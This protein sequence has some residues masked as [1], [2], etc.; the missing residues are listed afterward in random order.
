MR[1]S[2]A[3]YRWFV[4]IIIAVIFGSGCTRKFYRKRADDDVVGVMTEKNKSPLWAIENWHIYPDPRARFADPDNPDRPLK[5]PDDPAAAA[6]SPDPQPRSAKKTGIFEG[7]VYLSYLQAWDADNREKKARR[8][9]VARGQTPYGDKDTGLSASFEKTLK[10]DEQGFLI[11][12]EQACELSLFNSREYQDRREDLYASALPVTLERFSYVAQFSATENAIRA[13]TGRKTVDGSGDRW[14]L[15]SE[16]G[17]SKLFPSG[18]AL[19]VKLANR[20]VIELGNG[21]PRISFSTLAAEL[22]QPLLAGGGFAVTM[23]SLTQA[24]RNLLYAVRSYARFRKIYYTYLAGGNDNLFNS[25]Y[26]LVGLQLRG[27]G[28]TLTASGQGFYPTLLLTALERNEVE[29]IA[30][31]ERFWR[32]YQAFEEGGDVSRLQVDQVE[33]QLLRGRSQLLQRR[34][35]LQTGLDTF[36]IQL[37][38]PTRL[39]LEL[40]DSPLSPIFGHLDRFTQAR[41][42]FDAIRK[43]AGEYNEA[44]RRPMLALG[45]GLLSTLPIDI[46]LRPRMRTL[47]TDAPAVRGTRF[48]E[49]ILKRWTIWERLNDEAVKAELRKLAD[50]Q[51][52]LLDRKARLEVQG[53]V[54]PVADEKEL[55]R[56]RSEI[57]LG[58]FELSL[59]QYEGKPWLKVPGARMGREQANAFREVIDLFILVLGEA[60]EERLGKLRAS[61]PTL[62]PVTV[63]GVDV[64]QE[65]LDAAVT[66]ASQTA[67]SNRLELMNARAQLVDAWRLIA[68]R[69]NSLMGVLNVGYN[70]ETA[71]PENTNKPLNFGAGRDSHQL[72]IN[73]EL[74]LVRRAERNNY[75]TQ[76]IA[77][78]RQRRALQATEDLVLYDVRVS[79]RQLRVQAQNFAIQQRAVELAYDQVENSLEAL[80]APPDP[81]AGRQSAG[82]A[83][84]L[85]QQLLNAQS[86]LLQAQNSLYTVWINYLIARMQFYRELELLPIDPR[87]VWTD[88]YSPEQQLDPAGI[89][90]PAN[91]QRPE[92][93]PDPQPVAHQPASP[94]W[95]GLQRIGGAVGESTG[96]RRTEP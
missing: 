96:W 39:P 68:V 8:P 52:E 15:T 3:S 61:W 35:D 62:P 38:L 88:E 47:F 60:R 87:G 48:R 93:L 83:A 42:E 45:G 7:D 78:Q 13:V 33:Q 72:V 32:T 51:R 86:S 6:L 28:P 44:I 22:T 24:E 27:I 91:E 70:Y 10:T 94:A 75:R 2:S 57:N 81:S 34:Q 55:L 36:K 19:L 21:S 12:L 77:Y 56:V 1:L 14:L 74:P 4:C 20:L 46:A 64:L 37:G 80:Q 17:M 53:Q 69:A 59:R 73:G 9:V 23:E 63:D 89:Q 82:A 95:V 84:A 5:P 40:D 76:L 65:D 43:I 50:Q 26:S 25:P 79:L 71:T 16:G 49:I 11:N 92:R 85:P 29:N 30:G 41:D 54:F 66:A 67:L 90:P 31:L 18:A 58:R